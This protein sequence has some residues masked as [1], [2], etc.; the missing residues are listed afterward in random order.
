MKTVAVLTTVFLPGTFI[1]TFISMPL[2]S[3][4]AASWTEVPTTHFWVYWAIT[5]PLTLLTLY[6]WYVWQRY[7]D[8][9]SEEE[10]R[11]A[12]GSIMWGK[13]AVDKS[14]GE[15]K[16]NKGKSGGGSESGADMMLRRLLDS[17]DLQVWKSIK[18]LWGRR[19]GRALLD[20]EQSTRLEDVDAIR[21]VP[22]R[23]DSEDVEKI[24]VLVKDGKE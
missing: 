2:L 14:R 22:Q 13:V 11:Q 15:R 18:W 17:M 9:L 6:A 21:P 7:R 3:W 23:L 19:N 12:R 4:D 1:S 8:A 5:I 10:D 20:E 24:T 16:E